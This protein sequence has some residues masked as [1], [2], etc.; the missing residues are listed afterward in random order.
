MMRSY[1]F[2]AAIRSFENGNTKK[3]VPIF[4]PFTAFARGGSAAM[5]RSAGK[6]PPPRLEKRK[7]KKGA[8]GMIFFFFSPARKK[9]LGFL[10]FFFFPLMLCARVRIVCDRE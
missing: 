8:G 10:F 4:G 2:A 6:N 1:S 7:K 3:I 5:Y 9:E